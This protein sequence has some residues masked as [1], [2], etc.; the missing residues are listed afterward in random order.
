MGKFNNLKWWAQVA[1]R[2]IKTFAEVFLGYLVGAVALSE[3]N[4]ALAFSASGLGV[5]VS[6]LTNILTLPDVPQ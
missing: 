2:A 6:V 1:E 4:W 3:V 5:I